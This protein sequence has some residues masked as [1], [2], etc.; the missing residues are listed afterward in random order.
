MPI[1]FAAD[2]RIVMTMDA[3]GSSLRFS[4]VRG[5][6]A[7]IES[8]SLPTEAVDLNRCL[9]NI[10]RGFEKTKKSLP[11][12]PEPLSFSFPGSRRLPPRYHRR[13][14][15]LPAFRGGVAL[16]PMLED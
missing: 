7:V 3:G 13:P 15:N 8:F 4:A 5:N 6:Q 1:P 2:S 12:P 16:G 14:P 9:G 10:V 11:E